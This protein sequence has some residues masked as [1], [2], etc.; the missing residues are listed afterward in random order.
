METQVTNGKINTGGNSGLGFETA[1]IIAETDAKIIL[2]CRNREKG[3]AAAEKII[4]KTGNPNIEVHTLDLASFSS[5]RLFAERLEGITIDGLDNNAGVAGMHMGITE[6][7]MDI[8]FQSN[9]LGHF[10]LT[11]LLLSQVADNGRILNISSDMHNPPYGKLEWK[12]VDILAHPDD[13][14]MKQRYFYSKLCNLYF[15]YELDRKLR[16]KGSH[17]TVS[18]FNPGFMGTTNLAGG[19]MT[20]ERIEEVKKTMP[21]RYGELP[22]SAKAAADL[23][24]APEYAIQKAKYYDRSTEAVLSSALSYSQ[25]NAKELWEESLRLAGLE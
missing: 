19:N 13:S 23:M 7:G 6:D 5:V 12:G 15:T 14:V 1:K 10:L 8:V 2:G 20:Q 4:R 11:N 9:H 3:I 22:I 25:E 24:T 17:I 21:D 16:E 18:A